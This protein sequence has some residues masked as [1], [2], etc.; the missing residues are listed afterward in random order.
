MSKSPNPSTPPP[1][2]PLDQ[3]T[4]PIDYEGRD[5]PSGGSK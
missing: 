2:V 1:D 3:T 4:A 5:A